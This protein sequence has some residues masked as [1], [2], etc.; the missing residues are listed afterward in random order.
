MAD[1][2]AFAVARIRGLE[3]TLLTD[4]FMEQLVA[5]PDAEH[6]R[7]LLDEKG[8]G[9]IDDEL[10]KASEEIDGLIDADDKDTLMVLEIR[11]L[12]HNLK[13]AVK[14][15]LIQEPVR[16]AYIAGTDPSGEEME[17]MVREQELDGLP[18]NMSDTARRAYESLLHTRDGQLCDIIIDHD[19]LQATYESGLCSPE[20]VIRDYAR[21]TVN[22]ADIKIAVRAERTGKPADFYLQAMVP[23]DE[24]DPEDA[25]RAGLAGEEEL[26][27][28]LR[29]TGYGDAVDAMT[30]SISSFERWC[31]DQIIDS[32]KPQ[33]Y[34]P[35]TIGPVVAWYIA[36][37]MEIKSV[38]IILSGK[39]N[40]IAPE[41]IRK[42]IR[43]TYV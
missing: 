18:G 34:R 31:D 36:R 43:E 41:A 29:D 3:S 16:T 7:R 28:Y 26:F 10:A 2:Y 9:S 8:W 4:E 24:I 25:A 27:E 19:A 38:R 11:D 37:Q 23:T 33:L 1:T 32:M 42:R 20:E 40:D 15:V 13:A 21:T 6:C 22:I 39:E 5:A 17:R 35:F 30:D 14:N 12:Y